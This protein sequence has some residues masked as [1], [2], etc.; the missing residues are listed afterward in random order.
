[1]KTKFFLISLICSLLLSC[2]QQQAPRTYIMDYQTRSLLRDNG[3]SVRSTVTRSNTRIASVANQNQRTTSEMSKDDSIQHLKRVMQIANAAV[4][5]TTDYT[6]VNKNVKTP[7]GDPHDFFT[8]APYYWPDP[9]KPDGLPYIHKDGQTNPEISKYKSHSALA[10]LCRDV[11][12]L[13]I[14]Y[15]VT[16]DEKYAVR[17]AKLTRAWFFDEKTKMNPNL[18][19]AQHV[20]GRTDGRGIGL[21]DVYFFIDLID[22]IQ[23]IENSTSW[24]QTDMVS[25][26][27]WFGEFLGWMLASPQG[28]EAAEQKNNIGTFYD[29]QVVAYAL[30]AGRNDIA[31]K[32]INSSVKK[33]IDEQFEIDGEQPLEVRRT[34]GWNYAVKNLQGWFY[35]CMLAD[36]VNIDL[37]NYSTPSGKSVRKAFDWMVPY[38][39]GRKKWTYQQIRD[40]NMEAFRILAREADVRYSDVE[41][42][43]LNIQTLLK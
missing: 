23:L 33:R 36:K 28:K 14:A 35:L 29:M 27:S 30:F 39:E 10:N 15:N 22:G 42:E 32:T 8:L 1:M 12:A 2:A 24:S 17:A 21:I 20:P 34:R 11:Q 41:L 26:K 25:L 38:A 19:F 16:D 31:K 4:R 3:Q 37:W 13:G 7:S 43:S 18:R 40:E 5:R 6:V 9:K